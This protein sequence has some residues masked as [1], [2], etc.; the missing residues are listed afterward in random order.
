[1]SQPNKPKFKVGDKVRVNNRTPK[2][3]LAELTRNRPRTI[4]SLFWDDRQQHNFYELGDRGKGTMGYF[5]RPEMLSPNGKLKRG[6][7]NKVKRAYNHHSIC[8]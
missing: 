7:H 2:Y 6:R 8:A 1:M 3:I 4:V 5:F